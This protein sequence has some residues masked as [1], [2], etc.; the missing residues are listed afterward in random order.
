MRHRPDLIV[1]I[2]DRR[3]HKR[4]LTL[5][6]TGWA[7]LA[8]VVVFTGINVWSEIRPRVA[9]GYG[10]LFDRALPKVEQK[11]VEVVQEAVPPPETETRTVPMQ[12]VD[13]NAPAPL[14]APAIPAWTLEDQHVA[15]STSAI[16]PGADSRVAI[17]GGPEGVTI[18]RTTRRKPVLSGGFGR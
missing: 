3:Q 10:R 2:R 6:N 12:I 18:V 14:D 1:P 17:V 15:A 13:T 4:Y 16:A 9:P 8:V 11:P 5:R 7:A